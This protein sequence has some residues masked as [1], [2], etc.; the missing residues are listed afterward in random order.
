[1]KELRGRLGPKGDWRFFTAPDD[2]ALA[3]V[4]LDFGQDALP[5]VTESGEEN[6]AIGHVLKVFLVDARGDVRN[7][8]STGLLDERLLLTIGDS[9]R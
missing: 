1:M 6:G 3:P 8:Y 2:P 7:I 9:A 4:L 5:I